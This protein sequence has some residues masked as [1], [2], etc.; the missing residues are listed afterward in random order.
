MARKAGVGKVLT[1]SGV[2]TTA[3]RPGWLIG[4][5]FKL[6][7]DSSTVTFVDGTSGGTSRWVDGGK[8][9]AAGDDFVRHTFN[10]PLYFPTDIYATIAGTGANSLSVE[11]IEDLA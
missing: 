6:G 1:A 2:V 10:P 7:S 4:Y 3:G 9:T 5:C 11:Y 8:R